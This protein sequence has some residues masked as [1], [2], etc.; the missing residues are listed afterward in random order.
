[1]KEPLNV[2]LLEDESTAAGEEYHRFGVADVA[3]QFDSETACFLRPPHLGR[4][5]DQIAEPIGTRN[6]SRNAAESPSSSTNAPSVV[7]SS[8]SASVPRCT[9]CLDASHAPRL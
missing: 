2:L 3:V 4:S 1:M 6:Q 7:S 8:P 9:S 5:A